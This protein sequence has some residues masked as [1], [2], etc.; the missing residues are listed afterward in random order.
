[1]FTLIKEYGTTLKDAIFVDFEMVGI[2]DGVRY[3]RV[4]GNMARFTIPPEIEAVMKEVGQPFGLQPA[5][6]KLVG[7]STECNIL[8]KYGFKAVALI[9]CRQESS[10]IPEWHRL[11]DTPD[12]LQ[13]SSLERVQALAWEILQRLDQRWI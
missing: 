8:L 13:V 12:H 1:M 9:A 7:A 10:L 2:G 6:A 5:E 3:V 11:T 4:E